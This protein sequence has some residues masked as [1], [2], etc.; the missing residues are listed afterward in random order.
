MSAQKPCE[1]NAG[2]EAT[3][4]LQPPAHGAVEDSDISLADSLQAAVGEQSK[5][6][7]CLLLHMNS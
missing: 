1:N 3:H 4:S 7:V 6:L 5:S 2:D